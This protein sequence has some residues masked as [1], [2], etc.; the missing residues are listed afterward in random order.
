MHKKVTLFIVL[1]AVTSLTYAGQKPFQW[2]ASNKRKGLSFIP[3]SSSCVSMNEPSSV[4]VKKISPV[5]ASKNRGKTERGTKS[6]IYE[7]MLNAARK[8]DNVKL[9]QQEKKTVKQNFKQYLKSVE[10]YNKKYKCIKCSPSTQWRDKEEAC[11]HYL[12][13]HFGVIGW[14]AKQETN[15]KFGNKLCKTFMSFRKLKYR[16]K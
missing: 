5:T 1:A 3:E 11:N 16:K 14:Q 8:K 10:V 4:T 15:K 7:T 9:S 13:N 6:K 12:K 2:L